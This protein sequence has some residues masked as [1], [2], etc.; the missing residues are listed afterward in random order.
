M[1]IPLNS[2][3]TIGKKNKDL[4]IK[5]KEYVS[6]NV[7]HIKENK[8]KISIDGKPVSDLEI[9]QVNGT[10]KLPVIFTNKNEIEDNDIILFK[11]NYNSD[12]IINNNKPLVPIQ[13]IDKHI[14]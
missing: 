1:F 4:F 13:K 8:W 7:E 12:G 5:Y 6:Y 2:V 10:V 11:I 14:N 3:Y 9:P